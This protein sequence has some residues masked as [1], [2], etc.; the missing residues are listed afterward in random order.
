MAVSAS[1]S[2]S[3]SYATF[4]QQSDTASFTI[5][6]IVNNIDTYPSTPVVTNIVTLT[7]AEYAA[8]VTKDNNTYYIVIG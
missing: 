5:G 3:S 8:I 7:A 6:G 4:S 1:S 2:T